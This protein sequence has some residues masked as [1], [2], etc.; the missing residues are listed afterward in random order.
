VAKM[1]EKLKEVD[2][3]KWFSLLLGL[4]LV[5]TLIIEIVRS[6]GITKTETT[7]FGILQFVFSL[8]LAWI[9]SRVSYKK[10]FEE[11]Q[12]KFA[13]AAYRRVRED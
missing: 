5:A 8:A 6:G 11:G 3:S 10:E 4:A 13:I 7:L 12:R 2:T 9:L 1:I